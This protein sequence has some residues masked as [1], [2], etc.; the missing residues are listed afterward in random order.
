[1]NDKNAEKIVGLLEAIEANTLPPEPPVRSKRPVVV[2]YM[3]PDGESQFI[4]TE[5]LAAAIAMH[6]EDDVFGVV[7]YA[8]GGATM[9][10][11]EPLTEQQANAIVAYIRAAL[12]GEELD[13]SKQTNLNRV[14]A[15]VKD[16]LPKEQILVPDSNIIPIGGR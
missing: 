14:L 15:E 12:L 7:I 9:V 4:A 2:T 8:A 13:R 6:R 3:T 10:I 16:K 1:V 11:R 5:Q